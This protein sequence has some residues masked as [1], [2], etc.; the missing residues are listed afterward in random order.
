MSMWDSWNALSDTDTVHEDQQL[1]IELSLECVP[2]A[3]VSGADIQQ[4]L[5]A[6]PEIKS[7]LDVSRNWLTLT[8]SF[9]ARINPADGMQVGQIRAACYQALAD[10]NAKKAIPC[11]SPQVG[12]IEALD[13]PSVFAPSPQTAIS[14]A[15]LA[16]IAIVVLVA[17]LFVKNVVA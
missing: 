8:N 16:V 15:S 6:R 14:L 7:V 2:F 3:G 11:W 13:K 10:V 17:I 9:D 4:A 12:L 1:R 5:Q